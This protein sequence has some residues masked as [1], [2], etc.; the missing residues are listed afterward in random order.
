MKKLLICTLVAAAIPVAA[1]A[2][3]MPGGGGLDSPRTRTD[4]GMKGPPEVSR[5]RVDT[6]VKGPPEVSRNRT[7]TGMKGPPEVSRPGTDTM[8]SGMEG[9]TTGSIL[10]RRPRGN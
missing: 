4:T 6:G 10:P 7:D 1:S 2:Q 5:P 8:R 3:D 9:P